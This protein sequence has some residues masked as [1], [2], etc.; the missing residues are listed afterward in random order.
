MLHC[1]LLQLLMLMVTNDCFLLLIVV[2]LLLRLGL[3]RWFMFSSFH[4]LTMCDLG[5]SAEPRCQY[6]F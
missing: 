1:W 5:S 2:L 6:Q 3:L 4:H